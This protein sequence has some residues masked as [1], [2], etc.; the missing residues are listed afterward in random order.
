VHRCLEDCA[1]F[2]RTSDSCH[3]YGREY[4]GSAL[5]V[6][7]TMCLQSRVS[8]ATPQRLSPT[9]DRAFAGRLWAAAR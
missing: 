9:F 4:S 3:S 8:S 7:A 2:L 6:T 5:G 1:A